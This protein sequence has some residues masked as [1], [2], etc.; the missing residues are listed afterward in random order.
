MVLWR[1]LLSANMTGGTSN[2]PLLLLDISSTLPREKKKKYGE[3]EKV[4]SI[5]QGEQYGSG[6]FRRPSYILRS[7]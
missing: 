5:E 2:R 4:L 6:A 7:S 3:Q 1:R